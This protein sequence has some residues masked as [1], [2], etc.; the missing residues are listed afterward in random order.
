[1][2]SLGLGLGINVSRG[3]LERNPIPGLS[4]LMWLDA[5]AL[6]GYEEDDVVDQVIDATGNGNNGTQSVF[7]QM[8]LYKTTG[9]GGKPA[10]LFDGVDDWLEVP[11]TTGVAQYFA[12]L[13]SSTSTWN[14][15]WGILE[16]ALT[17]G[18][19]NTF[20]RWGLVSQGQTY[21][22]ND[23]APSGVRK[24]GVALSAPFDCGTITSPMILAVE[25]ANGGAVSEARG[26]FQL[27]QTFFGQGQLAELVAFSA[28]Q[29]AENSAAIESHLA[30][31][32]SITLP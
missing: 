30:R 12:V 19:H 3:L 32:Y 1:M 17:G 6:T 4:P 14:G 31:K 8:P 11:F 29:S 5:S 7:A 20:A 27:Q 28:V 2:P 16:A 24:N 23:P 25:T 10:L 13:K 18:A 26:I 21:F 22:H 15:F 9:I